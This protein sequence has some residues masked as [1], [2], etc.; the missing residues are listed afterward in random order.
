MCCD[1]KANSIFSS[2]VVTFRCYLLMKLVGTR[3]TGE[4][5]KEKGKLESCERKNWEKEEKG[6][7]NNMVM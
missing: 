6:T 7:T 2:K 5:G 4:K 1:N 3:E